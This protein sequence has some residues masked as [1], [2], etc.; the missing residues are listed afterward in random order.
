MYEFCHLCWRYNLN[1]I[2]L[3]LVF[4]PI[5]TI[6]MVSSDWSI[7]PVINSWKIF[8]ILE[9]GKVFIKGSY[10]FL[11]GGGMS[12]CDGQLPIFSGPPLW[13]PQ[14]ILAPPQTDHPFLEFQRMQSC[15]N[16]KLGIEGN[17]CSAITLVLIKIF[18]IRKKI[19]GAFNVNHTWV[20]NSLRGSQKKQ[21]IMLSLV[22]F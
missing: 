15:Q 21:S 7:P 22:K 14:N 18:A 13:P 1:P 19:F 9:S 3:I 4:I 6:N 11:A 10:H 16:F 20:H 17:R 8:H 5:S 2:R 12:V